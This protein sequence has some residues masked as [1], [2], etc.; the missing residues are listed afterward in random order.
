MAHQA[1]RSRPSRAFSRVHE[2]SAS[3]RVSA[4]SVVVMNPGMPSNTMR[5]GWGSSEGSYQVGNNDTPQAGAHG[6]SRAELLRSGRVG[7]RRLFAEYR[8]TDLFDRRRI[9]MNDWAAYFCR[10]P[11]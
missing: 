4:T 6:R 10:G 2:R 7:S 3:S 8:R 11:P 1:S 9:L 5:M